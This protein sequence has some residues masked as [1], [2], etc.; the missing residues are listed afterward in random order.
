MPS[1]IRL[2]IF[3]LF[4]A[5]IGYGAMFALVA[6]V[7]PGQKEVTVRIPARD[8]FNEPDR[9]PAGAADDTEATPATETEAEPAAE[10]PAAETPADQPE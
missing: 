3:L 9:S 4:L 8:L 10:E 2:I 5:G 6:F 1:L 7:E